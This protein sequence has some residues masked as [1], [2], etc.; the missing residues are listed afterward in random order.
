[1]T[2]DDADELLLLM[3]Q[4]WFAGTLIPDGTLQ[5]W[6]KSLLALEKD[7]AAECVQDLAKEKA[8]W[9]AISEFRLHYSARVRRIQSEIKPIEREYLPREK[10]VE[11]LRELRKSLRANR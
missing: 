1:M 8:F 5:L 9:P 4:L 3:S 6:H 10:N 11:R 7:L 2:E